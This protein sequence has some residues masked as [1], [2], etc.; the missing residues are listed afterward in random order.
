VV[1]AVTLKSKAKIQWPWFILFFCLA[2]FMNTWLPSFH[3]AFQLFDHLG[4]IGLTVTLFLI[5]TGLSRETMRVVG[6]RPLMQAL[7]L[8]IIVG[9]GSLALILFNWIH[10]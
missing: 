1:T 9:C 8:W 10:I 7:L 3:R 4:K 5:G 2:A 6:V